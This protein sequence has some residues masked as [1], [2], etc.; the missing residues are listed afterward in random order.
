VTQRLFS[1]FGLLSSHKLSLFFTFCFYGR[2][3]GGLLLRLAFFFLTARRCVWG[4]FPLSWTTPPIGLFVRPVLYHL[5]GRPFFSCASTLSCFPRD[6]LPPFPPAFFFFVLAKPTKPGLK[7]FSLWAESKGIFRRSGS[8]RFVYWELITL[9]S[10]NPTK[11]FPR[12]EKSCFAPSSLL[13][14]FASE[15]GL[16][17]RVCVK[18]PPY[19]ILPQTLFIFPFFPPPKD[20]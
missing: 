7:R 15:R 5:F 11:A 6:V 20:K 10:F 16:A 4:H 12:E 19:S 13:A 17:P 1:P 18:L 8:W 2:L 3:P 14:N 9:V